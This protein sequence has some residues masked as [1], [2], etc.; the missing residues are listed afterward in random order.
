MKTLTQQLSQY[1]AYHRDR[2]NVMTHFIGIPMI[3]LAR[4]TFIVG[5]WF[6]SPALLIAAVLT[7]Y[8]LR[9]DLRYGLVMGVL[10]TLS[11]AIAGEVA[12]GGRASWLAWGIGLFVVG[13]IIQF[14]G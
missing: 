12:D 4:P 2:R 8:Y 10:L 1:A 13:W 7:L 6:I 3:L 9:L 11:L 5:E 14:V